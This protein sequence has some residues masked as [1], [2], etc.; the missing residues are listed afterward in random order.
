MCLLG[1]LMQVI[2]FYYLI[3]MFNINV[4]GPSV[5]L[6]TGGFMTAQERQNTLS[7]KNQNG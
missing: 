1:R 3:S 4:N 7:D 5:W 2:S 6:T